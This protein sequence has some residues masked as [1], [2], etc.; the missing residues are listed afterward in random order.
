MA[1]ESIPLVE[2]VVSLDWMQDN[3]D[4]VEG[5]GLHGLRNFANES[6]PALVALI[7]LAW[8][9]DGLN[10]LEVEA[11]EYTSYLA[12]RE[13]EAAIQVVEMPFMESI[14]PSDVAALDSL[15]LLARENPTLLERALNHPSHPN[16]IED[17]FTPIIATL[18][19]VARSNPA[20]VDDLLNPSRTNLERRTIALP[21]AGEVTLAI[22]RTGPGAARSMD[23]LEHAVRNA[24]EFMGV[25]FP[26]NFVALLFEDAVSGSSAG[27]NFG[28]HIAI[29]PKYD[30][31]D[32][33]HEAEFVPSS[34][35]HEVAHYYWSGNEDWVDEGGA[36]LVES[37]SEA[38]RIGSRVGVNRPPCVYATN[39]SELEGLGASRGHAEYVC[40]YSLG[41]RLFVDLYRTLGK[42]QFQE[43]FRSL[44]LA[45]EVEDDADNR[46][47]T[48]VGIEQVTE[49]FAA[50][51]STAGAV[52]ARW[53]DGSVP[54]DLS[55]LDTS[56][57][58]PS[59]PGIN[60]RIDSAHIAFGPTKPAVSEFSSKNTNNWTLLV[61]KISYQVFSLKEE[62]HL[63]IVEFY[64]DG[65]EFSRR[66]VTVTAK[67]AYIGGT[68]SFSVG[69]SPSKGWALGRYF[70]YVY[71]GDR[72]VAEVQY[73]VT[74]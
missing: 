43:A 24:E 66:S 33:S 13:I 18:W 34:I 38:A 12:N 61:L 46:E 37:V 35:A 45:S 1:V 29:R 27:T 32:G 9:Q 36:D 67:A 7:A 59:L 54:Y 68:Y 58:D 28:S 22:I 49:A 21:L 2:S 55:A 19:G 8:M 26:T 56:P 60:G 63:D 71:D 16:G 47:G 73:T 69:A 39:L 6:T 15:R 17:S 40:N 52:I 41:Q 50:T 74:P 5:E 62:V 23:L 51:D 72:K 31:D 48:S 3:I 57:V 20:L 30:I 53:Y 10:S 11:I 42:E 65:T 70:V 4:E 25:P 14:E 44:Y 64:E